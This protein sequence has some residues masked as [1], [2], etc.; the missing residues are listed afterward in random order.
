MKSYK[1]IKLE[2]L[3]FYTI[4]DNYINYLSEY[5]NHIAYNKNAR[6]PYVGVVVI[7]DG[8][9]YFAP[10]FSPKQKHK[11][12]K[13]NLT[14]FRILNNKTKNVWNIDNLKIKSNKFFKNLLLFIH[15]LCTSTYICIKTTYA[16]E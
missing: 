12:Y 13:D 3:N 1:K 5:D 16:K 8:H 10:L 6:R 7:V 9:F 14:F 15:N 11:M 4:N 2:K